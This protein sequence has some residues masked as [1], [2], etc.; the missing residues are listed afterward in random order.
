MYTKLISEL[1]MTVKDS[2]LDK[3]SSTFWHLL[4]LYLVIL[5]NK[6]GKLKFLF[7]SKTVSYHFT[8]QE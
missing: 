2:N 7:Y 5:Q 8:K 3:I 1:P 4:R 6:N